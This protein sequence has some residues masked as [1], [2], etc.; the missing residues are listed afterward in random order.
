[1]LFPEKAK[2]DFGIDIVEYV[3]V[4]FNNKESDNVYLK[5]LMQRT[6][7]M[8]VANHLIMVDG[9]GDLGDPDDK[10]R[11]QSVENHY[12]WI[13]TAQMLGCKSIRVNASGKGEKMMI[14]AAV[15]DGLGKLAVF[16]KA[17]KI[18]VIVENHGGNSS[19]GQWLAQVIKQVNLP[20]C[21]TLP[22]FGNF[23][24][25]E[26][27]VYDKYQGVQELLPYA[28]GISAKTYNFD[29]NGRET[30]I[31]YDRMFKLIKNEGWH[32]IVGIEY[33]GASLSEDAGI[34]KTKQLLESLNIE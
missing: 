25:S 23:K 22:D 2:K 5:E 1:M 4:F 17:Y 30:D 9:E 21:G 29:T 11:L 16:A 3:S 13:I 7:D 15:T 20:N 28:K 19:N 14:A 26:H 8:H 34:L 24:I 31:D 32:G 27:E 12:K 18:N 6:Q 10:Q 33:E